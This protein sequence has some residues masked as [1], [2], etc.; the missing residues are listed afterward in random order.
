MRSTE[1]QET[2]MLAR[3]SALTRAETERKGFS[4]IQA[5]VNTSFNALLVDYLSKNV[6]MELLLILYSQSVTGRRQEGVYIAP[7]EPWFQN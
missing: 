1:I 4:S 2:S 6:L 3:V 5:P 7:S